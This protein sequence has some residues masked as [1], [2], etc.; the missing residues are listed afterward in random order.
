RNKTDLEEQSLDDLFN[1]LKIYET[2]VKHSSSTSTTTQN[3]AFVSSSNTDSTTDSVSAAASVSAICAKL[4]VSSLPNVDSLSNDVIYS[5][6]ASKS[7]TPQLDNEDLKQIDIDVDDLKEMDLKWQMAMLTM[8]ARRFL[9]K[10]SRNLGANG[11]TS[12]GF[13]M[14]K[15]KC[16]NCHRKGHFAR[17]C[18]SPNDL[19][20]PGA[21]EPQKRTVPVE[22]PTSNALVSQCDGTGSYDW[23]Y[24]AEEVPANYALMAFL[25]S[26]SN[27]ERNKADLEEQ[28]LDDLFNSLKLYETKVNQL[29]S[30]STTSQNLAFVSSSHTDST[31]DS[32]SAAASVST[33]C[34]KLPAFPL[35]NIDVDDLKEMD[36]KWQMAMLT[37]RA[38]RFLQKTSRNL[39]ANGPTSMGFDM[40]KVKCF[41]CHRKGHFAR[42]CK[43]P[44]D[45]RRPGAA[46]PQKRTVPVETPTSNAL[47][48]QCDGT[49]SY[50]WSY[51]AEEVPA[52]YALMAFLNSSSN[53]EVPTSCKSEQ[54]FSYITRPR[55]P[56][57]MDW[58]SNFENESEPKALQFVL[59]FAQS[60]EHVKSPRHSVQ[61]IKTTIPAATPAQP[62]PKSTSSGQRRNR[63]ACFVCK[64]MDHLIKD[65]NFHTKKMAKPTQRNYAYKGHHNQYAS[66]THLKPQK[67]M[68]PTTVLTQSRPVSNTA[69]RPVSATLP[70]L[71]ASV[72]SAAQGKQETWALK[73]KGV[74]NSGC[75]RYMKGNMSYLS[76]FEEL[77]G[78]YVAFGGNPN[79]G[80]I[81]SKCKIKTGKLDFNDVYFVNELKFNLFSVLQMC[82]KKNRVLFTDTECL[83]LSLDFKLP[84]ESQVLLRVPRE[85][86]IYNVNLKN[87]VRSGD[88]TCLFAK[89]TIDESN[90]WHR[91]LG[92]I[93]FKTINKLVKGNLVRGLPI[94]N[95]ENDNTCVACKKGKQHK[96]SCKPKPVS[97]IDQPLFKLHMDLFRPTFVKSLNKRI[98]CLVITDDY[99]R[100]TWVFFLATKD[101]TSLILKT[102]IT[103]LENQLSLKV[104]V[105]RSDNGTEC[106]GPTWFFDIDSL[107][108]TMNYQPV[109]A[110]NQTNSGAGFQDKFDAEKVK[111]E[112][113]QQYVLFPVCA[114]SR[115]QEDKTKKEA[116]GKSPIES[117]TGY[118]DLNAEFKDCSKNS[119]N[120]VNVVGSIVPTVR[121]NSPNITN[122]VSATGPSKDITYSDD[123]DVV[124]AEADFNNLESSILV[125]PIPT[126]RIHKD[127]LVSQI[128]NDMSSTTQ[129]RRGIQEGT[130]SSQRSK[131]EGVDIQKSV[132]PDIHS[133]SCGDQ[134]KEQGDKAKNKDKGK[135]PVVTITRFRDLNK[136]FAECIDNSSN[137]VNASGSS[138]STAGLNFTNNTN[139]FSAAGPSN[140]AMPNLEDFSH[141]VDDTGSMARGVR[142][143]GGIS[144]MFNEDFHTC[145]FACFLS[146]EEPKRVHQALKDPSWIEAMQEELLQFKM[147]KVWI[148]VDLPYGK[149]AISTKW[150]YR[151]KKD[152]RGIV[153]RNKAR[154]VAQGH[155]QEEGIDY[156]EVFAP[157]AR[158]K[159]I[160]LFL[161]YASFMGFPVCQ[162]DVKS[163]FLYGAIKE[164]VYVCQPPGFEDPQHPDKS[165]A[166]S[167]KQEDKT[168]K[169]AKGKSPIKSFTGYRDLNAEFKDCSKNSSNEVN[170]VG[171]IVPTVR[172]NSPNITN[173]VSATGPSNDEDVVGAEA[174]FNNLESSIL[175]YRNKKDEKGIV[176][177][178]KARLV[179]QGH[180]Q[181]KGIDYEE[182]F[183]PVV[184]IEAIGLFL[185]YASFMGFMVYQMDVKSEFLYGTIKEEVYVCQPSGFEDP[186][187]PDKV[188]K[189]VKTLYGLHQ[190]PRAWEENVQQYVLFPLWSTGSKDPQ[191]TDADATFEVKEP[192]SEVHV[193]LSTSAKTKKH[194]DKTKREAKGKIPIELSTRVRDLNDDFEEFF[195]NI[196]NGVNAASTPVTAVRPNSTNST[197]TFSV[198]GPSN[199]PVSSAFE[200]GD[201]SSYVNPSQYPDDPDMPA[202]E[203][204]TY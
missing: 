160:R 4:P 59:S 178:N 76:E 77:N 175:V 186:D 23:S 122:T 14:S 102:F 74:I 51:Q 3:L 159:A 190:A 48:S 91:R 71:T 139:D 177:R 152:E 84:D 56:I 69:V 124:G 54:D 57:I 188:Y 66:L 17:E 96:A 29:S 111:E 109:T 80:K 60:S 137:G 115:K 202:L 145:M 158:I 119:S 127:H 157:V 187:H 97:S 95:F 181:E 89:A 154:L 150:V 125:S 65:C 174:D 70:N 110:G 197:N 133:S 19:R 104:K 40:S 155:T 180:T 13:D 41:N 204:I 189:V 85:N 33:A 112:V 47:V 55:E 131:S 43:S 5:F 184:R 183:A 169:E 201:K 53:T 107:T 6:F 156:E 8:R 164:E 105:I 113:D 143:Q 36:L 63:K 148:L 64:S 161:A 146:Q 1:S 68:V 67:H 200:F 52:N 12:M 199:N 79:G 35:P 126:T 132:S 42:E 83:V 37:M 58:L 44:N 78:R 194:D 170:V 86:N 171:S 106:T 203:D 30:T 176:I 108:R 142:D 135:S 87:I 28:S 173:T 120:E 140:A 179:A 165:S 88:L 27:T 185:A 18:K 93:N 90:L 167:R 147:Q 100:F 129:T 82:D 193:S 21:A 10:T 31:T 39:G 38:R 121:Q 144:Q 45:L 151:N 24:Q 117:F 34:A 11:P 172:Q 32:I 81:T 61:P 168:K 195:D 94:K 134:A 20:R 192:N 198:A 101:K 116:K 50:D 166:Q 153:I 162:M 2:E 191:N 118:R 98:Y 163:A 25:N 114:Q 62:S 99:S 72:V 7:T 26:S 123:E 182:I 22:T 16:F 130:S 138:V 49:G 46:E 92:H 9:Q 149:R 141:N 15:V 196:T 103:G 136:E 75:S 73:D 128:I